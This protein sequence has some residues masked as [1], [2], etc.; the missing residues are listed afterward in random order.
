MPAR[1]DTDLLRSFVADAGSLT[2]AGEAVGRTQSALSLRV[3]QLE[4]A[5]GR[6]VFARGPR[7]M[8][9]T[10]A[11]EVLLAHARRLVALCSTRRSGR[12]APTS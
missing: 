12:C 6:P 2:R 9:L 5:V 7:G 10:P 4:A 1:L 8:A 3:R 11:G